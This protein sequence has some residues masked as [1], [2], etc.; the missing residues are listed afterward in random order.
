MHVIIDTTKDKSLIALYD[1]Q[2]SFFAIKREIFK[3]THSKFLL[4]RIDELLNKHDLDK[5]NIEGILCV[6][7]PGSYTG[8]RVG[9]ATTN[10][11][12]FGLEIP[13]AT[14]NKFE[15]IL[16]LKPGFKGLIALPSY[17]EHYLVF[18][19]DS[20]ST[21]MISEDVLRSLG[22][23]ILLLDEE[24]VRGHELDFT[25]TSFDYQSRKHVTQ[26]GDVTVMSFKNEGIVPFY[27]KDPKIT[28]PKKKK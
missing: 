3:M 28:Q 18:N 1:A 15:I 19:T 20:K 22:Q 26:W 21:K 7:G 17:R 25:Y 4:S 10:A 27:F 13:V 12:A 23:E 14:Y 24:T 9:V 2:S 11:L 8:S 16:T 5:K 6:S